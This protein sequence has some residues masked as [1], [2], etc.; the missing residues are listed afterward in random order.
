VCWLLQT[1]NAKSAVREIRV[2]PDGAF[3]RSK[4][5]LQRGRNEYVHNGQKHYTQAHSD[6]ALVRCSLP[7]LEGPCPCIGL[8][9]VH[10]NNMASEFALVAPGRTTLINSDVLGVSE[11]SFLVHLSSW[12]S[13]SSLTEYR[14][15]CGPHL[16]QLPARPVRQRD[17]WTE[18]VPL[19][20]KTG[21]L[22]IPLLDD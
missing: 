12:R 1:A 13:R 10:I 15:L 14:G 3:F 6:S 8:N 11:V 5:M 19:R 22:G 20:G 16:S 18:I 2:F 7:S 9:G 4:I 21:V 17:V